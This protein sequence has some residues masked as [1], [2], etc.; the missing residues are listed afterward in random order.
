MRAR[1]NSCSFLVLDAHA[2]T[3]PHPPTRVSPPPK[4]LNDDFVV[5]GTASQSL[6]GVCEASYTDGMGP[7]ELLETLEKCMRNAMDRDCLSGG[8]TVVHIVTEKG[9]TS[10]RFKGR[11]D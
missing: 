5:A 10:K 3:F 11:V 1:S 8:D 9:V 6:Y 7:E 2:H 4:V